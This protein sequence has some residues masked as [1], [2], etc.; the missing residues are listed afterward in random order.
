[1]VPC[2]DTIASEVRTVFPE[3]DGGQTVISSAKLPLGRTAGS[4][5]GSR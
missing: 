5:S 3:E 4:S 2:L 1:M